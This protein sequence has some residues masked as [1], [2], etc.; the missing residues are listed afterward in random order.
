MLVSMMTFVGVMAQ[1]NIWYNGAVVYQRDYTL[2]DSITFTIQQPSQYP[3][4]EEGM[5]IIGEATAV[6]NLNAE[7]SGLA[8][9]GAGFNEVVKKKRAGMYEKYVALEGGKPFKF[10][11]HESGKSDVTYGGDLQLRA[12]TAEFG[13]VE[14]D[15]YWGQL[16]ENVEMM[17]PVSGLYHVVLDLNLD[18]QL[19]ATGGKQIMLVPVTWGIRGGFIDANWN[20]TRFTTSA[21]DF[22]KT[23]MEFNFNNLEVRKTGQFRF[24]QA[25][26]WKIYLDMVGQVKCETSLGIENGE[27]TTYGEE[28]NFDIA[29]G[30]YDIK[31]TWDLAG[32]ACGNSFTYTPIRTGD[33]A[34]EEFL[35]DN[36]VVGISGSM[37]Y[38]GNPAGLYLAQY[39]AS[40]SAITD[41]TTT[42]G[43]Y[44][45][46]LKG[47]TFPADHQ[48]KF[49]FDDDWIGLYGISS[50]TGVDAYDRD[51]N[52]SVSPGCYDIDITIGWD[53]FGVTDIQ[54]SFTAGVP[55]ENPAHDYIAGKIFLKNNG[56][57]TNL[58]IYGWTPDYDNNNE[59]FGS[60]P[61]TPVGGDATEM[62]QIFY[63][64]AIKDA[65]YKFIIN[66]GIG[67]YGNQT[68]DPDW[69]VVIDGNSIISLIVTDDN[70]LI[71]GD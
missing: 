42:A 62:T 20:N 24:V 26:C 52:I 15:V 8:L 29:P 37:N 39:S 53:G 12:T 2:I 64:K 45:F 31:L 38:W 63:E 60:W 25:D 36:R 43:N 19:T 33:P 49:R 44:V 16:Q 55:V 56:T 5:Y 11:L 46:E 54:A 1:M 34:L 17:V 18:G 10:I 48:F 4:L 67:G 3:D 51:G 9:M 32:G 58:H 50:I 35:P 69:T 21:S 23:H 61:G 41:Q 65:T 68:L 27:I 71:L 59:I 30:V 70:H 66:E 47:V 14:I 28:I 22:D 57:L 13:L 6:A 40:K 7:N